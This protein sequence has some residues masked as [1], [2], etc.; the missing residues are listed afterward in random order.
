MDEIKA[1]GWSLHRVLKASGK[2]GEKCDFCGTAVLW[3]RDE[4]GIMAQTDIEFRKESICSYGCDID[5]CGGIDCEHYFELRI[6]RSC[7]EKL[8]GLFG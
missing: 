4:A 6:C 3:N 2:H 8:I 5:C 7:A 1:S